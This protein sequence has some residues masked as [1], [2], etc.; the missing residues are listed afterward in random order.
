MDERLHS[1]IELQK[2]DM[3]V[4][5]LEAHY[6]Q[7][8]RE[9]EKLDQA[10]A[11][12]ETVLSEYRKRLDEI[13]RTRRAKERDVE[14]NRERIKKSESQLY[15][16]KTNRDYQTML[17]QIEEL[18][19]ANTL[20][21]DEILELLDELEQLKETIQ[22]KEDEFEDEK[23][24]IGEERTK[25]Q[26]EL[27][28]IGRALEAR[29]QTRSELVK[30]V[31]GLLLKRYM[32]IARARHNAVVPVKQNACSGCYMMIRPAVISRVRSG[33]SIVTC[34]ACSRI[35]YYEEEQSE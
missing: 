32:R 29:R 22:G 19:M 26:G 33:R 18:K 14:A 6:K 23:R 5:D 4:R 30:G 20:L 16:L 27:K 8:P 10:L 15:Q 21:D 11:E 9:I 1:L 13:E 31:E 17:G 28:K 3:T 2:I 7:F 24:R 35:L 12:S 34:D 25:L